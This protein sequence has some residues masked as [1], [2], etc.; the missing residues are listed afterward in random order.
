MFDTLKEIYENVIVRYIEELCNN[1][2][3]LMMS[4]LDVVIV[5]LVN[6]FSSAGS[7]LV[8]FP[9]STRISATYGSL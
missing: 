3:L 5:I 2:I 9:F 6:P 4:I 7:I 8:I 1:P